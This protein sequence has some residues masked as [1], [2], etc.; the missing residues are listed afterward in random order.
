M[1]LGVS[2]NEK[3]ALLIRMTRRWPV[4]VGVILLAGTCGYFWSDRSAPDISRA[5]RLLEQN[6][7]GPA[8]TEIDRILLATPG[9]SVALVLKGKLLRMDGDPSGAIACFGQVSPKS[10]EYREASLLLIQTLLESSNLADAEKQMQRH[11]QSFPDERMIWDELR[12]LCFNQFRT[13]D[14]EELSDWWL[15]THPDDNQALTHLLLGVFR[16]QVPQEGSHYLRQVQQNTDQQVPVLRALAWAAW[17]S[18][19][20]DEARK[21]LGQAWEADP[22]DP[23]T[24]FL[25]AGFLIEEQSFAAAGRVLGT[26]PFGVP[27]E[28]FGD[29]TDRWHWLQSRV[30]LGR[31]QVAA[32]LEEVTRAAALRDG[33]LK[34]IH[35]QAVLLKQL[36]RDEEARTAFNQARM[37]EKC[38]KR[39]AE[40]AFSGDWKTPDLDLRHELADLYLQ[41]GNRHVARLWRKSSR[42]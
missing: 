25:S 1:G 29:Q 15:K 6:D 23:R 5:R 30:L 3:P 7:T 4:V 39:F 28:M 41:C 13:R 11:L 38:R 18:G 8:R 34:Y 40:I 20:S 22:D 32:A 35:S 19:Q 27:G 9:H 10:P 14:V 26:E 36:G 2:E 24:R 42:R 17:Q 21:L 12:W 37:I 33:D 31:N 16:P